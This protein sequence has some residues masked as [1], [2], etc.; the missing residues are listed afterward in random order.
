MGDTKRGIAR[1]VIPGFVLLFGSALLVTGT[2]QE[3]VP[4]IAPEED[5]APAVPSSDCVFLSDPLGFRYDEELA[6]FNRSEITDQV[7]MFGGGKGAG[8]ASTVDPN[9]IPRR[10]L[11]D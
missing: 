4:E 10:T 7:A 3:L 8:A 11:I 9:S 5:I 1:F 2:Q 6:F